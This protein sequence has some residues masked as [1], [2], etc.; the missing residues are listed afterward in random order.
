MPIKSVK[1][2]FRKTKKC[3]SFS[4]S[5]DH[6]SQ[7]IRFLGQKVCPAAREQT[8][9]QTHRQTD[10]QTS[11]YWGHPFR[12]SGFFF[13]QPVSKDRPNT[14]LLSYLW[15]F[16]LITRPTTDCLGNFFN[17]KTFLSLIE[18]QK[19]KVFNSM[20]LIDKVTYS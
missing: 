5:K 2:K 8:H 19:G 9:R 7:K 10:R 12:V 11:D 18:K 1:W 15:H 6:S 4:C 16:I 20:H 17:R 14:H 3:V 13:L